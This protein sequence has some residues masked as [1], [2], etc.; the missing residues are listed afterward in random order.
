VL[1]ATG[2]L[3]RN[4]ALGMALARGDSPASVAA[5]TRMVAEGVP[6]VR[7]ALAL[8]AAHDVSMPIGGEVAAVLFHQ[9]APAEA[10]ASLLGRVATRED[11]ATG[12]RGA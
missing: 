9:K 10:L 5:R 8:A 2:T 3:S 6:T 12:G 11:A 7:T 4:R 1:T